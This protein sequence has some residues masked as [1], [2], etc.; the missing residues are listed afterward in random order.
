MDGIFE[1]VSKG[2]RWGQVVAESANGVGPAAAG[3]GPHAQQVDKEVS[4]ELDGHH[5][6]D[7]VQVGDEGRLQNDGNV[8]GVKQLDGIRG[9]LTAIAGTLDGQ[10][11]AESLNNTMVI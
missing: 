2:L 9:V 8:G 11:H 4:S 10:V 7:D 6:R 3:I 1:D 5:L